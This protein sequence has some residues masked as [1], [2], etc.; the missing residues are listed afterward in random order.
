VGVRELLA[1]SLVSPLTQ[2]FEAL[3]RRPDH[4]IGGDGRPERGRPFLVSVAAIGT[5]SPRRAHELLDLSSIS[6]AECRRV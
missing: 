3:A 5:A 2:G 1:T 6:I 4:E